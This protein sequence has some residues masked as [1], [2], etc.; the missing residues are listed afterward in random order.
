MD[1]KQKEYL[2]GVLELL[3]MV[4]KN[5]NKGRAFDLARAVTVEVRGI[6]NTLSSLA[7]RLENCLSAER[8]R[9]FRDT[10]EDLIRQLRVRI[11]QLLG[12]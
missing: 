12:G 4:E 1:Q 10:P 9:V 11:N 3:T 2:E 5:L 7:L 6:D 8:T